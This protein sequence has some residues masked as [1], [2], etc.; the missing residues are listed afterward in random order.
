MSLYRRLRDWSK[1]LSALVAELTARWIDLTA[2]GTGNFHFVTALVAELGSV[3]I[4]FPAIRTLHRSYLLAERGL[5]CL[6][7]EYL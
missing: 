7:V 2:L 4:R 3:R 1:F 5:V 6:K